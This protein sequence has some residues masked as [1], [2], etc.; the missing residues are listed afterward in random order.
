[1]KCVVCGKE[2][3]K[4]S[5]SNAAL[6]SSTCYIRHFWRRIVAE[7]D[8][9]IFIDGQSYCDG[10]NVKSPIW[11]SDL[12]FGGRRFWIRFF[13]GKTVTTNNLWYQGRIPDE[14]RSELPDNAKFYTPKSNL[15]F[16][17]Y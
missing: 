16:E 4:S 13:D 11:V 15:G 14:F 2:M 10:G 7:K 1:M 5:Y 6:C 3:L 17:N 12:G 8:K 9:H